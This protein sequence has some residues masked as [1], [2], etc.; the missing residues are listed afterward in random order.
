MNIVS[1][2]K[3]TVTFLNSK[4]SIVLSLKETNRGQDF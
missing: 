2:G 3:L 1:P 4:S